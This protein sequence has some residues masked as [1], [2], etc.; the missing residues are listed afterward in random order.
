[1]AAEN[2]FYERFDNEPYSMGWIWSRH[3]S[4]N[5]FIAIFKIIANIRMNETTLNS[6]KTVHFEGRVESR[7]E[8][9]PVSMLWICVKEPLSSTKVF[10]WDSDQNY[11]GS[12]LCICFD[13][14]SGM[15]LSALPYMP[16]DLENAHFVVEK[17]SSF[18][19]Q[20]E[21]QIKIH[22][23]DAVVLNVITTASICNGKSKNLFPDGCLFT[24]VPEWQAHPTELC[25]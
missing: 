9:H 19:F 20:F 17:G 12:I 7:L 22:L 24:P 3:S 21:N 5:A 11:A 23:A 13:C 18:H 25:V 16:H 6:Q 14:D 8:E 15:T 10:Q 4:T 2:I 1:M